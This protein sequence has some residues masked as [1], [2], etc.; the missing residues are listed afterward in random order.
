[1][2]EGFE[3]NK[4][5]R[6]I[7]STDKRPKGFSR[8]GTMDFICVGE[9]LLCVRVGGTPM[10]AEFLGH[11]NMQNY[12]KTFNFKGHEADFEKMT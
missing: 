5:Y 3:V 2:I 4:L 11:P 8:L 10:D 1:M 7:G 12:T 9:Q 6:W